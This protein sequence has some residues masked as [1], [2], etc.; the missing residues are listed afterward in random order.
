MLV[1]IRNTYKAHTG[2]A[3]DSDLGFGQGRNCVAFRQRKGKSV[4]FSRLRVG[5]NRVPT[6]SRESRAG[7][8]KFP[9]PLGNDR[10]AG[11]RSAQ[12]CLNEIDAGCV[13][14][15]DRKMVKLNVEFRSRR[16]G[17]IVTPRKRKNFW[18]SGRAPWQIGHGARFKKGTGNRARV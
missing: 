10:S 16:F 17:R 6:S 13:Q 5:D 4:G 18:H 11:F 1:S 2:K 8:R 12:T 3:P 15:F 9:A 7:G 14:S